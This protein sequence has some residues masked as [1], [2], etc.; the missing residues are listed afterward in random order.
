MLVYVNISKN[1]NFSLNNLNLYLNDF[2][3]FDVQINKTAVKL[4]FN[5]NALK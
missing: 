5:H 1:Y 2:I 4:Q 3:K